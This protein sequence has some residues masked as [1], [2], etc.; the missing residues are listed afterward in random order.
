MDPNNEKRLI[1]SQIIVELYEAKQK[2]QLELIAMH[3]KAALEK[4][5]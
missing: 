5:K 2:T 3:V 1:A 4:L